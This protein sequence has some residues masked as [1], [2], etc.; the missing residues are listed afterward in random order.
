MNKY[1]ITIITHTEKNT[2]V[3]YFKTFVV[4]SVAWWEADDKYRYHRF[5]TDSEVVASA[6]IDGCIVRKIN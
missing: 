2:G 6:P 5:V 4:K 1:E 3:E